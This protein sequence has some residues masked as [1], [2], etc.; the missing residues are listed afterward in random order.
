MIFFSNFV[1]FSEYLNFIFSKTYPKLVLLFPWRRL[2]QETWTNLS[3][4]WLRS[5]IWTQRIWRPRSWRCNDWCQPWPLRPHW[6]LEHLCWIYL[7]ETFS[8]RLWPR[9]RP[10]QTHWLSWYWQRP[11]SE[12]RN[13]NTWVLNVDKCVFIFY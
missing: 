1:A 3:Q 4:K 10:F 11:S 2:L 8:K 6:R 9:P 12:I 5:M 7:C 13:V